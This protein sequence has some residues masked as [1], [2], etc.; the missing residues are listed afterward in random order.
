[1]SIKC[2]GFRGS[3]G[4]T[5]RRIG[6]V[7]GTNVPKTDTLSAGREFLTENKHQRDVL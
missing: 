2:Y 3:F 5:G 7:I 4:C 1:M 6:E